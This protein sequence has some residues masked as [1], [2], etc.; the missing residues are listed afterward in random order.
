MRFRGTT[1]VLLTLLLPTLTACE[2]FETHPYDTNIK[3]EQGLTIKNVAKIESMNIDSN[4]FRFAV[5]SDTQ[6]YYDELEEAVGVLNRIEDLDFVVHCGDL[7]DF[8]LRKEFEYQRNILLR[9]N[10]PWVTIIGNHDCLGTGRIVY[11]EIFGSVN[12]AFTAGTTRFICLNT[13]AME[14]D[15]S[16][17]VPDFDFLFTELDNLSDSIT[18]VV[19][20]MHV[21]PNAIEFNTNVTTIFEYILLDMTPTLP[22][23]LYGHG[24]TLRVDDLFGDGILYYQCPNIEKRTILLFTMHNEGYDY[25]TITY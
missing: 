13:N 25:E 8:G 21:G 24:H 23:C 12:Y 14:F 18:Q 10:V 11:E 20:V 5:I 6:G 16:T 4:E 22:F 15:Y 17:P 19:Y 1:I 7:T 3:G 2:Y 9:L